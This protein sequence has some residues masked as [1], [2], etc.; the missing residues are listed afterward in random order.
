MVVNGRWVTRI[1]V[2][3]PDRV[4]WK[5][6]QLGGSNRNEELPD[7][8]PGTS[9]LGRRLVCFGMEQMQDIIRQ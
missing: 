9:W 8:M 4:K 3:E 7:E 5:I 1:L 6:D 2:I